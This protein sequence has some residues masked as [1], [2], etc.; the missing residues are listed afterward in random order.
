MAKLIK[1]TSTFLVNRDLWLEGE[2]K[3]TADNRAAEL[4][5]AGL[6]VEVEQTDSTSEEKAD[7]PKRKAA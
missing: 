2:T 3:E 4:I 7:K 6:A 5:E 1:A